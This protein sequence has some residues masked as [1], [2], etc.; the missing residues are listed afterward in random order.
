VVVGCAPKPTQSPVAPTHQDPCLLIADSASRLDTFTVALLDSVHR[1]GFLAP[2]NDSELLLYRTTFDTPLRLNCQGT[3]LP[4]FAKSWHKDS[5]GR[6]WTLTL[7]DDAQRYYDSPVT[8]HDVVAL[9]NERKAVESSRY[10]QS[11]GALDDKQISVTLASPQDSVPTILAD[12]VFSLAIGAAQRPSG[13][14]FEILAGID[15][16]D[17]LDRGADLVVTRDPAVLDY[18]ANRGEFTT[19]ALPWSRTYALLQPAAALPIWLLDVDSMGRSLAR[20][21]A[22]AEA[23]AAEPPFWWRAQCPRVDLSHAVQPPIS[24]LIVY[25]RDDKVARG[26]AER[27]VALTRDTIQLRTV[28]LAPPEF[29]AALRQQHD[30]GYVLSLPRQVPAPCHELAGLPE[31]AQIRPL[32]DTRAHAIVRKGAPPLTVEWDGTVRVVPR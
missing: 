28:G 22:Q 4:G 11:A 7:K 16:R 32:I 31:G 14:R 6:V 30:R 23:R 24:P 12:P 21:V 10:L 26:L 29:A 1:E 8:A 19:F 20:D 5:T 27:M 2:A 3:A 15:A 9:W 18:V 25:P 13:V 17:A